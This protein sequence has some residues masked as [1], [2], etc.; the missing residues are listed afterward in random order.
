[1]LWKTYIS[2][3]IFGKGIH[4]FGNALLGADTSRVI[5]CGAPIAA[6]G[7][8]YLVLGRST[9]MLEELNEGDSIL[10]V[11][12]PLGRATHIEA[13]PAP[14]K[15][16]CVGGGTGVAIGKLVVQYTGGDHKQIVLMQGNKAVFHLQG[17]VAFQNI[18]QLQ[19]HTAVGILVRKHMIAL[20]L[21]QGKILQIRGFGKQR[22]P[23]GKIILQMLG[24]KYIFLHIVI[25]NAIKLCQRTYVLFRNL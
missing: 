18:A 13:F 23:A 20:R 1:M 5:L 3:T 12:G 6:A 2:A 25:L 21:R 9:Q 4:P 22:P 11:C 14:K 8:V 19:P 24:M 10:D 7:I 17:H 16:I 15:V